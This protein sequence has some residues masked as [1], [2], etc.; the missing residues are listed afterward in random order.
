MITAKELILESIDHEY[1]VIKHLFEKIPEGQMDFKPRENM[2]STIELLRYLAYI[3]EASVEFYIIGT[4]MTKTPEERFG[5]FRTRNAEVKEMQP[6]QF[7]ARITEQ[8]TKTHNLIA[9]L[10]DADLEKETIH[11]H[12]EKAILLR[13]LLNST[14]KWLTAYRMQ[15][16]IYAKST[17]A[18]IGT[19]NNWRGVDQPPR[20]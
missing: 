3:G 15:L 7:I 12:G 4:D 9:A 11:P 1:E 5:V 8:K 14:L 13:A 2:R 6:E 10:T 16:F 20:A 18:E 19:A 17:G